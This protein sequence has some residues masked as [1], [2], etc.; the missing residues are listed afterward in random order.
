MQGPVHRMSLFSR[1][2]E[3][4]MTCHRAKW[5]NI[6]VQI[7]K[8]EKGEMGNNEKRGEKKNKKEIG[9]LHQGGK[10]FN[11]LE[12]TE[13]LF[14]F[15]QISMYEH[16][17]H[18]LCLCCSTWSLSHTL[19]HSHTNTLSIRIQQWKE[20]KGWINVRIWWLVLIEEKSHGNKETLWPFPFLNASCANKTHSHNIIL[21]IIVYP[22]QNHLL[23]GTVCKWIAQK[24]KQTLQIIDYPCHGFERE[25][26]F[27]LSWRVCADYSV[28][29]KEVRSWWKDWQWFTSWCSGRTRVSFCLSESL[30]FFFSL[31][32]SLSTSSLFVCLPACLSVC[33]SVWLS[34]I[35]LVRSVLFG[36]TWDKNGPT[37]Q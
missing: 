33:V 28:R 4:R 13:W 1:C 34:Q 25:W 31:S 15:T 8:D 12:I 14:T 37:R 17:S 32:L 36:L 6:L 26:Q 30:S 7:V 5:E 3:W 2:P 29:Q 9:P 19:K 24:E 23:T 27:S 35:P 20:L 22:H 10:S 11:V 16:D 18:S 21:T